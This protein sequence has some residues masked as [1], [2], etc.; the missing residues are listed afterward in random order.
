MVAYD[1]AT[2]AL[3]MNYKPT[4]VVVES[5]IAPR[6]AHVPFGELQ[7]VTSFQ[8]AGISKQ[9]EATKRRARHSSIELMGGEDVSSYKIITYIV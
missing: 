7:Y 2:A 5:L 3:E 8:P 4:H 1:E 9:A 6:I